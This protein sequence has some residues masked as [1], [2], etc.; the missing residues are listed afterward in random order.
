M[1]KRIDRNPRTTKLVPTV[2]LDREKLREYCESLG[3]S[4]SSLSATYAAGSYL[5][6]RFTLYDGAVPTAFV[7]WC[8]K[9]YPG[10]KDKLTEAIIPDKKPEPPKEEP[11]QEQLSML[12]SMLNPQK[13][14]TVQPVSVMGFNQLVDAL[15]EIALRLQKLEE[16][17]NGGH[18]EDGA[19]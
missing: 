3:H 14:I 15:K 1:G 9:I 18:R 16:A 12:P 10:A 2:K 6:H 5:S 7:E 19:Q 8:N 4:E 11:K 17:W 13:V